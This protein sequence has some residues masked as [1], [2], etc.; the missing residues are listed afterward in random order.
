M[1]ILNNVSRNAM[2]NSM[3]QEAKLAY[4]ACSDDCPKCRISDG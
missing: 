2:E 3:E 4:S 1:T